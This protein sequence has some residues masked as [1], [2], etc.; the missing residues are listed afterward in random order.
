VL[1][2]LLLSIYSF[3]SLFARATA[4]LPLAWIDP[5]NA[6]LTALDNTN[7]PY[8]Q[9]FES[10]RISIAQLI[11]SLTPSALAGYN[12]NYN[13]PFMD[14]TN[15]QIGPALMVEVLSFIFVLSAL[16]LSSSLTG[17]LG[18]VFHIA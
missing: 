12:L 2:R 16:S 8:Q 14:T 4:D 15:A 9:Q 18:L 1:F 13:W 7:E 6:S 10:R 11:F 17:V 3:I 5:T